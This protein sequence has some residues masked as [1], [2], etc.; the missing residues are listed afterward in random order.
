MTRPLDGLRLMLVEDEF[1]VAVSADA[2]LRD[3][4]AADVQLASNVA[5]GLPLASQEEFDAAVLDVNLGNERSDPIA[6]RL[7]ERGIPYIFAT[8]YSRRDMDI[9]EEVGLIEKP[10]TPQKL[11]EGILAAMEAGSGPARR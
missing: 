11:A 9:G 5:T 3:L 10:Y 2:M 7:E 1:L 8:G 4:G 6:Q